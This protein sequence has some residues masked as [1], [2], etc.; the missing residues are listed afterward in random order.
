MQTNQTIV[1]E[2]HSFPNTQD[3]V[4]DDVSYT[5]PELQE[6]IKGI[7][8]LYTD[9]QYTQG[10][11]LQAPLQAKLEISTTNSTNTDSEIV[12]Q[13]S[14]N[15]VKET[16]SFSLP[17]ENQ[18][19]ETCSF[20]SKGI[21]NKFDSQNHESYQQQ[22]KKCDFEADESKRREITN[23]FSG[24]TNTNQSTP[25]G[26]QSV[27]VPSK[28]LMLYKQ[29]QFK[30]INTDPDKQKEEMIDLS[31]LFNSTIKED[32]AQSINIPSSIEQFPVLAE[33]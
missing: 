8:K 33:H 14:E 32:N 1:S 30:D 13:P 5:D 7:T 16:C 20:S 23:S 22:I 24:Q 9:S 10:T 18:V 4:E 26:Q 15:Q 11:P 19:K 31:T 2:I 27:Q 28:S 6:I 12:L 21:N 17:S 3:I 25:L 29:L